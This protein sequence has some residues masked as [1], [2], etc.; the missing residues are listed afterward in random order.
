MYRDILK[1]VSRETFEKLKKYETLLKEANKSINLVS[2]RDIENIW[3]RHILDSVLGYIALKYYRGEVFTS[4]VKT[5]L[6]IGS[7]GGLPGVPMSLLL[8]NSKGFLF[9]SIQKKCRALQ[10]FKEKLSLN[11]EVV[12]KRVEDKKIEKMDLIT[13]RGVCRLDKLLKYSNNKLGKK[14]IGIFWK[15]E[16]F[17]EEIDDARKNWFFDVDVIFIGDIMEKVDNN[18]HRVWLL[19]RN[20]KH[21]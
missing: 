1:N 9:E 11:V 3:D 18:D 5:F 17:Q 21:K 20:I 8:Q 4:D 6:D 13:A 12:N 7:G 19:V 2:R 10:H 15:G 16:K 14:G